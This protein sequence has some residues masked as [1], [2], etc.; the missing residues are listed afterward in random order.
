M[1][2][3]CPHCGKEYLASQYEKLSIKPIF[4]GYIYIKCPEGD[5]FEFPEKEF[6]RRK[7]EEAERKYMSPKPPERL[8][9]P[10][11]SE[12]VKP[13]YKPKYR[14]IFF[15]RESES[16]NIAR[17]LI[18]PVIGVALAALLGSMWFFLASLM[19]TIYEMIPE[20]GNPIEKRI[21]EIRKRYEEELKKAEREEERKDIINQLMAN[22][23]I[24][25]VIGD[26]EKTEREEL[27]TFSGRA[28]LKGF[29][30]LAALCLFSL[31]FI[32]SPIPLAKPL[33]IVIMFIAY[34]MAGS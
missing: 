25:K 24:E 21:N 11:P 6:E 34:F 15:P 26:I 9:L 28:V 23:G 33:G 10:K 18:P 30:K 1:P 19:W 32:L 8:M 13:K 3:R 31:A 16:R 12:E 5:Y 20:P 17:L 27:I 2:I 22:I 4:S 7:A 29:L 14:Y